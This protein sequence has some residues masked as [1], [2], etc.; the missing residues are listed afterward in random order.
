MTATNHLIAALGLGD[1]V[2]AARPFARLPD[3]RRLTH[4]DL[5]TL[6]ARLAEGLR[7]LGIAPDERVAAQVEKSVEA[8]ALYLAC[9]RA[10]AVFLPLNPAYTTAELSY[11]LGNASPALLVADPARA[12][13]LA[14]VAA[15]NGARLETLDAAGGGSLMG[16]VPD[17]APVFADTPRGPDDLAAILYTSGTTGRAK[18]AMLSHD[19]LASN[20]AALTDLW[21]FTEHDLLIHALPIFHTH[22]LFVAT[23]VILCAG[24]ALSLHAKFDPDAVLDDMGGATAL[25]GVPT[26]YTRLLAHPGLTRAA[27]TGMRVFIS[28]SAPMLPETHAEWRARTGHT[29]LERYGMTE[30]GMITSNP[31]EGE[32]RPGS[33][34]LPLPGVQLRVSEPETARPLAA[35]ETGMVELRG[36]NLFHGYWAMPDKTAEEMRGDGFFITGDLGYR[37]PDGYLWLVGRAKDLI[38]SGGFNVYPREVEEAIDAV[39]GVVESAVIGLSHP[40][41]GEGVAAVVVA[42][43][44]GLTEQAVI[45]AVAGQL[46]RYKQ[47]RRVVFAEALP[48]NS[49]GKVQKAALRAR[50]ADLF[51]PG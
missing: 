47:P 4:G 22:G 27:T 44:A 18:G 15:E 38:I 2:R 35:G 16:H 11:F 3:G 12:D 51:A 8:L 37:D 23:N 9:A 42:E 17:A 24:G 34:G 32:R 48:R 36:P 45:E 21:R 7:W 1:T 20:A 41:L 10:G 19:N 5:D 6:T 50:H 39:P 28:G 26:F 14:N 33:V 29:I 43:D 13:A 46:A 25:M 31:Y 49:M 40:D 30:T